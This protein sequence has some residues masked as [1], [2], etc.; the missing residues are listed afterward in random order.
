VSVVSVVRVLGV[1]GVLSVL[2]SD[3][4]DTCNT[5]LSIGE[6]MATVG[7]ISDHLKQLRHSNK[8]VWVIGNGGSSANAQ[9]LVLHLRDVGIKAHDLM[10]LMPNLTAQT[11]DFGYTDGVVG[12]LLKMSQRRDTLIILSGSG[13][14]DNVVSV[15]KAGKES[16]LELYTIALLGFDGGKCKGLADEEV[17]VDS[18]DYGVIEDCHSFLIHHIHRSLK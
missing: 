15:L 3:I 14:S 11:N 9:H 16:G 5:L 18:R 13:N 4:L 6:H 8:S 17:V 7:T 2:G 12:H 10:D 1:L